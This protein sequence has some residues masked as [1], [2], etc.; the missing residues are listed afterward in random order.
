M[1]GCRGILVLVPVATQVRGGN[2][3]VQQGS[4]PIPRLP[5]DSGGDIVQG[6]SYAKAVTCQCI[7]IV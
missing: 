5:Q 4:R 7:S 6:T 1:L 2:R 3:C